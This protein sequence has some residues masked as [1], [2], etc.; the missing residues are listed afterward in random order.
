MYR[1]PAAAL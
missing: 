1:Q